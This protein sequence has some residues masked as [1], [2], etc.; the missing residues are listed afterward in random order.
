MFCGHFNFQI[1]SAGNIDMA[2]FCWAGWYL[3]LI[4]TSSIY[5]LYQVWPW[6]SVRNKLRDALT[7]LCVASDVLT[8]A[9][10]V[11]SSCEFRLVTYDAS[12]MSRKCMLGISGK[13]TGF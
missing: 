6:E 3:I 2:A 13:I 11:S 7:E 5:F 12:C 10:K 9:T 4:F 8:I 1:C